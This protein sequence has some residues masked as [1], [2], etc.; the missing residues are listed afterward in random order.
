MAKPKIWPSAGR[1]G[2]NIIMIYNIL[3]VIQVKVSETLLC[4]QV[5]VLPV[6]ALNYSSLQIDESSYKNSKLMQS[7][8]LLLAK[9]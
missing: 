2:M 3:P 7:P 9:C 8:Q 6:V 1:D 5:F 4:F